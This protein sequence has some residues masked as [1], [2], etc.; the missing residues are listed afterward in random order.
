[1]KRSVTV[2][3]DG[4]LVPLRSEATPEYLDAL[5]GYVERQIKEV[6]AG[7]PLNPYRTAVLAALNIADELFRERQEHS[8]LKDQ[9]RERC[10]RILDHVTAIEAAGACREGE[11]PPNEEEVH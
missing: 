9:V 7:K 4:K 11:P 8:E 1:V 10:R 2:T 5:A 6:Q 3:I